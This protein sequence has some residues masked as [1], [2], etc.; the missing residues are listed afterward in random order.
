LYVES[1]LL[2][3]NCVGINKVSI[4]TG[5]C[6]GLTPFSCGAS[7]FSTFGMGY[8]TDSAETTDEKL[9]IGNS[10]AAA[11]FATLDVSTGAV[12]PIGTLA[13]QAPEFT[14]NSLGELWGF[15]PQA[16]SPTVAQIDKTNG[17]FIYSTVVDLTPPGL[18]NTAWAFAHWGGAY[19]IFYYNSTVDSS[20][21]VYKFEDGVMTTHLANTGAIIVGAGVSTCAPIVIE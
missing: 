2:G 17:S 20:T 19:Y 1:G 6:L 16:A 11:G 14:G 9:Y 3:Y 7:G 8:V 21:N 4:E 18:G 10:E 5:E 15:F 12:T 13:A